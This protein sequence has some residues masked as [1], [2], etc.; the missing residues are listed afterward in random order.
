MADSLPPISEELIWPMRPVV[1][2]FQALNT[3]YDPVKFDSSGYQ[4]RPGRSSEYSDRASDIQIAC[5]LGNLNDVL[6]MY[7][8]RPFPFTLIGHLTL[9]TAHDNRHNNVVAW[10]VNQLHPPKTVLETQLKL[11]LDKN[12]FHLAAIY[13]A[14]G[15]FSKDDVLEYTHLVTL[16]ATGRAM[17]L[18]W[19]ERTFGPLLREEIGEVVLGAVQTSS[20]PAMSWVLSSN[21]LDPLP[22]QIL[23]NN[24]LQTLYAH[25]RR[26][27]PAI[28]LCLEKMYPRLVT[29]ARNPAHKRILQRPTTHARITQQG[30]IP[31]SRAIHS[32]LPLPP[33]NLYSQPHQEIAYETNVLPYTVPLTSHSILAPTF[34]DVVAAAVSK[35]IMNGVPY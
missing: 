30:Y 19:L 12:E 33:Q 32:Y 22:T 29:L 16:G 4:T 20:L 3:T 10:I 9:A 5:A 14:G 8:Q 7:H 23:N 15:N 34:A 6:V 1:S 13:Q 28:A 31:S 17:Y 21:R 11:A 35:I 18:A 27:S 2:G 25:A 24:E 26:R